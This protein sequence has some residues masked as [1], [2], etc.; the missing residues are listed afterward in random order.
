MS[1]RSSEVHDESTNPNAAPAYS[2]TNGMPFVGDKNLHM[3][4][5]IHIL[6]HLSRTTIHIY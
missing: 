6:L 5:F 3:E 2:N 4:V 1:I